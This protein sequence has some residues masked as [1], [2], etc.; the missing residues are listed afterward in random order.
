MLGALL[1]A[2]FFKFIKMLEYES[3][4]PDA[5]GDQ[6]ERV[7]V[8]NYGPSS[9]NAVNGENVQQSTLRPVNGT[10][11][12]GRSV[13]GVSSEKYTGAERRLSSKPRLASPAM[14]TNDEAFHGLAHGMH[15]TDPLDTTNRPVGGSRTTSDLV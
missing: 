12:T 15:G 9:S 8:N 5:E 3:A 6:E 7:I 1:A 13:S 2:G 4:N 14:A 10:N 11:A